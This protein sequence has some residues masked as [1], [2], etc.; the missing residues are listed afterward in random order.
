MDLADDPFFNSVY[1]FGRRYP[2]SPAINQ[3]GV[4]QANIR[5]GVMSASGQERIGGEG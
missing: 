3:P 2:S 1:E 5:N 4:G